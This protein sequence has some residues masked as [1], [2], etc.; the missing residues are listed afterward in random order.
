MLYSHKKQNK[1]Q[2]HL[3]S[4]HCLIDESSYGR[5]GVRQNINGELYTHV[6]G[7]VIACHV[8]PI[9]KKPLYHFLP[10]TRSYSIATPGCN[11]RCEFCQNWQISQYTF[12]HDMSYPGHEMTPQQ[13]VDAAKQN[14]CQSIA[15]TYTEPTIFYEYAYDTAQIAH[16][17]NIKNIFVTNGYMTPD[18]IEMIGPYLDAANVDLKSF[19]EEFYKTV[20]QAHLQPV[21]QAIKKLNASNIWIEITTLVVPGL[22]DSKDELADIAAFIAKIDTEIPWHIT[23]FHPDYHATEISPTPIDTLRF[24]EQTGREYGL[25]NIHLGNVII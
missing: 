1:V 15:Y 3:C 9:E 10:G 8:D 23:R 12:D 5:C 24:A 19:R 11:F 25:K 22:N 16:K 6:Y 7:R 14:R 4:H 2:C 18:A 21:L 17:N 13:I 20:C